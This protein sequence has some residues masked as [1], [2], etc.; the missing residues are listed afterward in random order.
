MHFLTRTNVKC[1][2]VRETSMCRY[3]DSV[4]RWTKNRK[5]KFVREY[6]KKWS[7]LGFT[8]APCSEQLLRPCVQYAPIISDNAMKPTTPACHFHLKLRCAERG[9]GVNRTTVLGIVDWWNPKEW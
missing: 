5:Q 2:T 6:D 7:V 4:A 8:V 9:R 3:V 1:I